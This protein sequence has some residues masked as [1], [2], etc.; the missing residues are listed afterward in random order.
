MSKP[1]ANVFHVASL[2]SHCHVWAG[3]P[4]FV[5]TSHPLW[6]HSAW[7]RPLMA[8]HWP[9]GTGTLCFCARACATLSTDCSAR[10]MPLA[11]WNKCRLRSPCV[12]TG[13]PLPAAAF[14]LRGDCVKYVTVAEHVNCCCYWKLY[15]FYLIYHSFCIYF[16]LWKKFSCISAFNP[17]IFRMY[18]KRETKMLFYFKYKLFVFL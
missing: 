3:S 14:Q 10:K 8:N 16:K 7:P 1:H 17:H 13:T 15:V 2:F 11:L 12:Q 18:W 6:P 9:T 5:H 4:E